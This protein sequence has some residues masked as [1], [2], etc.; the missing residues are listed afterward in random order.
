MRDCRA[1]SSS[2]PQT[3]VRWGI[4]TLG[5]QY[6]SC[7]SS[8]F[9]TASFCLSLVSPCW[10]G[11]GLWGILSW[12]KCT[13]I[14]AAFRREAISTLLSEVS[15]WTSFLF[16]FSPFRS[17][18]KHHPAATVVG[19]TLCLCWCSAFDP[20][21]LSKGVCA[22]ATL[23]LPSPLPTEKAPG[24]SA[25]IQGSFKGWEEG[26]PLCTTDCGNTLVLNEQVGFSEM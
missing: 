18:S 15:L 17:T 7:E 14:S 4:S 6:K 16:S 8:G 26:P 19:P 23:P 25:V 11:C 10:E 9:A 24:L 12:L 21:S 22:R 20:Q 1:H 13:W 5:Q 3:A 2:L